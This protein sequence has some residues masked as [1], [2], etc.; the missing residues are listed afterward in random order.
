MFLKNKYYSM[1][2]VETLLSEGRKSIYIRAYSI[3]GLTKLCHKI[4]NQTFPDEKQVITMLPTVAN[5][6]G[7][8]NGEQAKIFESILQCQSPAVPIHQSKTQEKL[9]VCPDCLKEDRERYGESYLHLSHHLPGVKVCAKHGTVLQMLSVSQKRI[10][11]APINFSNSEPVEISSPERETVWMK[12]KQIVSSFQ[13]QVTQIPVEYSFCPV[14]KA[15]YLEH[16]YSRETGCGC[17]FCNE[18]SSPDKVIQR[19]LDIRWNGEYKLVSGFSSIF[20]AEVIH[21]ICGSKKK[22]LS[23]LLYGESEYCMECMKLIPER[24]KQRFD[25]A[26]KQW[27]FFH[28]SDSD[29][30]K[31]RIRVMHKRC[32]KEFSIFMPQ[33]TKIEGGYCPYCDKVQE[34]INIEDV[35]PDYEVVGPYQ[36]NREAVKIR[37][38]TCGVIFETSK[39]SFLSGT[40]CPICVPR[41]SFEDLVQAVIKC[42]ENYKIKKGKKRGTVEIETL[43]GAVWKNVYYFEAMNDLKSDRPQIFLNRNVRYKEKRSARKIIYEN[44]MKQTK[45]KGFWCFSDGLDGHEVSRIQRNMIQDMACAG[46]LIRTGK[47]KYQVKYL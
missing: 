4:R 34:S 26:E 6:F 37:H 23:F 17:P 24:L 40:R 47:G 15:A 42:T 44:V 29:R 39:T 16:S 18:I 7:K 43:D 13:E 21:M 35:D 31:K 12:A 25:P 45:E 9:Y 22:K 10:M 28:N 36:N 27:I 11:L 38:K 19:R 32:G 46:Y 5:V 8:S 3:T 1:K 20:D 41:Y 33:F 14:C 30:K 2:D